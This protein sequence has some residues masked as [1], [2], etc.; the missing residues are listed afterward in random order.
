VAPE[1]AILRR[2]LGISDDAGKARDVAGQCLRDGNA[3]LAL[4]ETAQTEMHALTFIRRYRRTGTG[5]WG[6]PG[7]AGQVRWVRFTSPDAAARLRA[8]AGGEADRDA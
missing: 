7:R 6:T 2:S 8:L 1:T 5:W 3:R 4:V